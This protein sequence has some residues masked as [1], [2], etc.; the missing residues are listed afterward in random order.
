MHRQAKSIQATQ[1]TKL[2]VV[3]SSVSAAPAK[4]AARVATEHHRVTELTPET[5]RATEI[6]T[7]KL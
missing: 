4:S 2:S 1:T 7:S 3:L 6:V 5:G